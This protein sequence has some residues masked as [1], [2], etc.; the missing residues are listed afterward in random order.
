MGTLY[1]IYAIIGVVAAVAAALAIFNWILL[2]NTSS[3]IT[4]VEGEIAKK[5]SEFD[6]I[7]KEIQDYRA[8]GA[9]YSPGQQQSP[10]SAPAAAYQQMPGDEQIS[11]VR[12]VRP[13]FEYGADAPMRQESIVVEA[14]PVYP[15]PANAPAAP[16][17]QNAESVPDTK[18]FATREKNTA[19]EGVETPIESTGRFTAPLDGNAVIIKLFSNAKKDADFPAAWKELIEKLQTAQQPVV[20]LDMKNILFLYPKEIKYI[21]QF[22][23]VVAKS[24]RTMQLVNCQQELRYI[25]QN[26]PPLALC[27]NE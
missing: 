9:H 27:I 13:G 15:A 21:E 22:L 19:Y 18:S 6:N 23:Q 5:S 25:L 10:A 17:V 11:I 8:S 26:T 14:H 12:N 20:H 2:A 1:L 24:G 16:I 4:R 7:R 3:K